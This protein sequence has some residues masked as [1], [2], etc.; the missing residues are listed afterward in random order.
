MK[1][2]RKW[3]DSSRLWNEF[4]RWHWILMNRGRVKMKI[5]NWINGTQTENENRDGISKR[6]SYSSLRIEN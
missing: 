3:E 1:I 4:M 6:R 5:G 2:G